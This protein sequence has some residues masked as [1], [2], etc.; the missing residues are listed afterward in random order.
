L[1]IFPIFF[2]VVVL[3]FFRLLSIMAKNRIRAKTPKSARHRWAKGHSSS[4]NPSSHL[5]RDAAKAKAM[6]A[7]AHAGPAGG[8]AK[9]SGSG[10]S[11]LT[12]ETLLKHD[13]LM[14]GPMRNAVGG[15][16]AD[17]DEDALTLGQTHKTFDTFASDW[18]QCSNVSFNRLIQRFNG[19][20]THHREMLAILAAVS[21]VVKEKGSGEES[22]TEYFAALLTTLEMQDTREGMAAV[23]TLLAMVIKTVGS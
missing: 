13:A 4:S 15:D 1:N 18:T 8:T 17:K 5:H 2:V 3:S 16:V 7:F 21:E 22:S 6:T 19:N 14:V 23:L 9:V 12:E 10:P 20:S 11:K